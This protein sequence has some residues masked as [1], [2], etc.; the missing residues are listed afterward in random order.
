MID[1]RFA[2]SEFRK[3]GRRTPG[4]DTL[5]KQLEAEIAAELHKSIEPAFRAVAS[6]LREL[7]HDITEAK[8]EYGPEFATWSYE[9]REGTGE[10]E[11]AFRIW[12]ETQVGV[13]SGYLDENDEGED[14]T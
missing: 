14:K 11:M 4:K 6:R 12:L 1:E 3:L 7:G 8:A 10:L 9:H 5:H 13:F 2:A